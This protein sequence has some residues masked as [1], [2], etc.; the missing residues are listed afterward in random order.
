ME[1]VQALDEPAAAVARPVNK[2]F[3]GQVGEELRGRSLGHPLHPIAVTLPIGAWACSS[4]LD[5]VPGNETASRRLVGIGLLSVPAAAVLGAADYHELSERQ[6]RV[7]FCHLV[8]NLLA[9]VIFTASYRRRRRGAAGGKLLGVL[10]LLVI[11]A[12]GALGG[13]LSYAQGAGVFRWEPPPVG[14]DGR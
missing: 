1:D 10:G 2:F 3:S 5:L 9:T 11:G 8:L 4:L 14:M 6:R 12:G 13:H 7:G